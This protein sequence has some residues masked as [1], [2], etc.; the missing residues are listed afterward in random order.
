MMTRGSGAAK[1]AVN[2]VVTAKAVTAAVIKCMAGRLVA[3]KK[4]GVMVEVGEE[5]GTNTSCG[6]WH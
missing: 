2:V 1:A 4:G 5:V 6:W 3:A